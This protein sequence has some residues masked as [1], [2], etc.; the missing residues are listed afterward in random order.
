MKHPQTALLTWFDRLTIFA[1]PVDSPSTYNYRMQRAREEI[2]NLKQSYHGKSLSFEYCH[3]T[4]RGTFETAIECDF[5]GTYMVVLKI[6]SSRICSGPC[7]VGIHGKR[8]GGIVVTGEDGLIGIT[9][10]AFLQE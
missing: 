5:P 7:F 2:E 4:I 1:G 6:A 3:E 10:K 9:A 8:V